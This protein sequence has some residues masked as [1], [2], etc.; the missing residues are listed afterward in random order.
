MAAALLVL[1]ITVAIAFQALLSPQVFR[2]ADRLLVSA[3]K[4]INDRSDGE[5]TGDYQHLAAFMEQQHPYLDPDMSLSR[6]ARRSGIPAKVL[7]A[8]I[9]QR[10]GLHFFDFLNHY[11]IEHAQGLLTDS[12]QSVTGI[13]YASGFNAKSSFNTAF[14]KH[15]GMTP[16]A[17]R[18][19]HRPK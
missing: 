18:K 14:K 16:S 11:R 3:A 6:L 10:R 12:D 19:K 15:V 1:G 5:G 13:L 7:S 4:Q 2:G 8:L 9:N 17:Y